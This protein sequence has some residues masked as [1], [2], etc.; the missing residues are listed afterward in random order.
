MKK[1]TMTLLSISLL[2]GSIGLFTKGAEAATEGSTVVTTEVTPGTLGITADDALA[3]P[4]IEY[5]GS[6]LN[7]ASSGEATIAV[8]DTRGNFEGWGVTVKQS[9]AEGQTWGSGMSLNLSDGGSGTVAISETDA[10]AFSQ[11]S[12]ATNYDVAQSTTYTGN[13]T[14]PASVKAGTYNTTLTW[15]LG[16]TP[17]A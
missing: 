9:Q 13:L 17:T 3:F 16:A 1:T 12:Q 14:I 6:T 8:N 7:Q 11:A 5:T 10:N 2:A 15:T 4:T